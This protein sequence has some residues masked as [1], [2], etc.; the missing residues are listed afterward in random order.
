MFI[1]Q[2]LVRKL[3]QRVRQVEE[4]PDYVQG[5]LDKAKKQDISIFRNVS[6]YTK[7]D[8]TAAAAAFAP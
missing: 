3:E 8:V 2:R 5:I 4:Y 7:R 6:A 1:E